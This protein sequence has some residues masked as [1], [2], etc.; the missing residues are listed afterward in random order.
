MFS[1]K[2][3]FRSTY[4]RIPDVI[5]AY[6]LDSQNYR[7]SNG[8]QDGLPGRLLLSQTRCRRLIPLFGLPFQFSA[9]GCTIHIPQL[10]CSSLSLLP[11]YSCLFDMPVSLPILFPHHD[12]LSRPKPY[13]T[14]FPM[15]T[16]QRLNMTRTSSLT[17]AGASQPSTPRPTNGTPVKQVYT[18]L[19][20]NLR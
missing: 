7:R 15:K 12:N 16:L 9:L 20:A 11:A 17:S 18:G 14:K 5:L 4:K 8:R 1:P 2:I 10:I 13:S 6:A 19:A 3:Q